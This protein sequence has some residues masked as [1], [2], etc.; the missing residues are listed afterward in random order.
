MVYFGCMRV[1]LWRHSSNIKQVIIPNFFHIVNAFSTGLPVDFCIYKKKDRQSRSFQTVKKACHCE[2]RSDVAIRFSF[3]EG[4]DSHTSDIGHWFGM[5]GN[6]TAG[7]CEHRPLRSR[8]R[9][10]QRAGR[11]ARPYT[12]RKS[13]SGLFLISIPYFV[14]SRRTTDSIFAVPGNMSTAAART[15]P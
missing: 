14:R 1:G 13:P 6:G 11:V 8:K 5:T 2:E 12:C 3:W 15:A 10:V 7:R 4:T 9:H